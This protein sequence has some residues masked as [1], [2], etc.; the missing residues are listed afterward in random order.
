VP[1][2]EPV[3]VPRLTPPRLPTALPKTSVGLT[4]VEGGGWGRGLLGAIGSGLAGLGGAIFG[5]KRD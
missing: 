5:K 2:F 1:V 3:S 4:A